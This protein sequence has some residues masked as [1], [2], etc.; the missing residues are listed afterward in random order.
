[1]PSIARCRYTVLLVVSVLLLGAC[2]FRGGKGYS[3]QRTV[4]ERY[5]TLS[6]NPYQRSTSR[7]S[8]SSSSSSRSNTNKASPIESY[9]RKTIAA[10]EM[11]QSI[12]TLRSLNNTKISVKRDI[13]FIIT[14]TCYRNK[15]LKSA[16]PLIQ[17]LDGIA[18]EQFLSTEN[19]IIPM[20]SNC[21]NEYDS[22]S[23]G[24]G[25]STANNNNNA[26]YAYEI[27]TYL[28]TTRKVVMSEKT[29]SLLF[30]LFGRK[31]NEN[32]VNKLFV[33]IAT[34]GVRVD[35]VLLNTI[36]DSYIRCEKYSKAIS[37]F[38]S[39]KTVDRTSENSAI[40]A[41]FGDEVAVEAPICKAASSWEVR[42]NVRT[43]NTIL[44]CLRD[45]LFT[46]GASVSG[47][48][49]NGYVSLVK[50]Y[51][52]LM[53]ANGAKPDSVTMNT[54]IDCSVTSRQFDLA[55]ELLSTTSSTVWSAAGPLPAPTVE[56]YTSVI[57]GY[58]DRG[59]VNKAFAVLRTML[60]AEAGAVQPNG[61]TLTSLMT[62]CV[63]AGQFR[64]ALN[65]IKDIN[66][67]FKKQG[68]NSTNTATESGSMRVIESNV[69]TL[70]ALYCAYVSGLCRRVID[71][72]TS[73]SGADK[74]LAEAQRVL[75]IMQSK[76]STRGDGELDWAGVPLLPDTATMNAYIQ[77]LCY[78]SPPRLQQAL[79]VF[80]GLGAIDLSAD[81]YTYSILFTALG[82]N[83]HYD[84]ALR[85]YRSIRATDKF[86]D[87]PAI[88]SLL[89]AA[90]TSPQPLA[91]ISL[92]SVIMA[93]FD[94]EVNALINVNGL[95][96]VRIKDTVISTT[97]DDKLQYQF[98]PNKITFTNLFL[99][100]SKSMMSHARAD[101]PLAL[102]SQSDEII[103]SSSLFDSYPED[104]SSLSLPFA[105]TH[106][107]FLSLRREGTSGTT[108]T[109]IETISM[110]LL[111]RRTF[112][113]LIFEYKI[114]I[115]DIL[116]SVIN[117]IFMSSNKIKA[118]ASRGN[119]L[120][121]G[122]FGP[123]AGSK[124]FKKALSTSSAQMVFEELL[125]YGCEPKQ[126][127]P[128]LQACDYS[129]RQQRELMENSYDVVKK[130][131]QSA[132]TNRIFRKY[133]WNSID[134][135]FNSLGL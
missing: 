100:I 4:A 28:Q 8:T 57:S 30:K 53:C 127:F 95:E 132:I 29:Y 97:Q 58:A 126:L 19:D 85:V 74:Y 116:L 111:V 10:D 59:D 114:E 45:T 44:K 131:R 34:F 76:T 94:Q 82:K 32:I 89:R 21:A 115:D 23:N 33:D 120:M 51:L 66:A 79:K 42:P 39:L 6:S 46:T 106:E 26:R 56:A 65:L 22:Y 25:G 48:S 11:Q 119:A 7:D 107:E 103:S 55:E 98:L 104:N 78:T 118:D 96:A 3:R 86:I 125:I 91:A 2:G 36:I 92:Y 70:R 47:D 110:D 12:A 38:L 99:A 14:E 68:M 121:S 49:N 63:N 129:A 17:S 124:G 128:I 5:A 123:S 93:D 64:V 37:I 41:A 40:F 43:Y 83:G 88:N 61:Y 60:T 62:A 18:Q 50:S 81:D 71:A 109:S 15:N 113:S 84:E 135:S 35:T 134:S 90:V 101:E 73:S 67:L 31:K 133:K 87:L 27:V 130:I 75:L 20:L 80:Y 69:D 9:L 77:A 108:A 24:G 105:V 54:L 13:V 112:H 1:M 52:D 102:A 122:L 117:S 16:L 72:G